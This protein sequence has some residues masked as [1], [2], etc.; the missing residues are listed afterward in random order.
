MK[1]LVERQ[2]QQLATPPKMMKTITRKEKKNHQNQR[3]ATIIII[4]ILIYIWMTRNE[5]I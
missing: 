5:Q 4:Q 3:L 1:K 2:H